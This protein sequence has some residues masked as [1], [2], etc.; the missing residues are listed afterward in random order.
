MLYAGSLI[1][2]GEQEKRMVAIKRVSLVDQVYD[3][4][5]DRIVSLKIPF[6]AKL[7]VSKLQEEYGVSS[8]PVREALKRLLNEGLV[9]IENNVGARVIDLDEKDVREMQ[10]IAFSYEMLA[11][12][13]AMR[14][15]DIAS[16]A[17][18]IYGHI[19]EYRASDNVVDSCRCIR[20][21]LHVFY[22]NANNDVLMNKVSSISG[23]DQILHSLFAMPREKGGSGGQYHS[24]II[25]FEQI[26]EAVLAGDFAKVCDGLEGHQFWSRKYILK[27]LETVKNRQRQ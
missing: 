10:E 20:N 3:K 27:N 14:E 13:N 23:M 15:G 7:N 1:F 8:T 11:A 16:M 6:G 9:E 26:H 4:L 5:Y 25:Y 12:R 18:E 19:E 17:A 21:I 22:K 2:E 24:G